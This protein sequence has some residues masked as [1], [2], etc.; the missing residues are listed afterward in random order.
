M[1]FSVCRILLFLW[2]YLSATDVRGEKNRIQV[3][4]HVSNLSF[5]SDNFR[6]QWEAFGKQFETTIAYQKIITLS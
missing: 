5:D 4:H 6:C 3:Q 1:V 2:P